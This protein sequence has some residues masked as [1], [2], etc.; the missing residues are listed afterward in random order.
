MSVIGADRLSKAY[1]VYS[2]PRQRMAD[3]LLGR[4]P[5]ELFWALRD[6]SFAVASGSV[7]G[8]IGDNGAGK[9]TLLQVVAGIL[10]PTAGRLDVR[11]RISALM[12]LGA[13]FN[14]EFTGR[15]NLRM[16]GAILGLSDQDLR[17]R[18]PEIIEFA[19]LGEFIDRPVRT[20]SSG[21]YVR[22]AFSLATSIDPD[23]L[24]IDEVLAVGDQYFQK[25]CVDRIQG[26]R[27]AGKTILFCSHNLYLIKE[28]CDHCLWL[29]G[30]EVAAYGETGQVSDAYASYVRKRLARP[31][32]SPSSTAR[33]DAPAWISDVFLVGEDG[34]RKHHFL[35]GE[36]MG[37]RVYFVTTTPDFPVH[38]G[39]HIIRNDNVECFATST[40]FTK[41][42]LTRR[43]QRGAVTLH[44]PALPLLSGVYQV[45]VILL[46]EHGLHPYDLR[47]PDCEFSVTNPGRESGFSHIEHEWLSTE[48][49]P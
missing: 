42:E 21:M 31:V 36:A 6:V 3:L 11:G 33:P 35:T 4:S 29:R 39:V 8:V 5:R 2:R 7:L 22:L 10:R 23:V 16:A 43:G 14:P 26:F 47:W 30:G 24:V 19:E 27:R 32:G 28:L 40:H 12:E 41:A 15:E 13:G 18:L 48:P 9:S 46:D 20:Y 34:A 25:K 1:P 17:E 37:V 49:E 45:S 38:V 44:F